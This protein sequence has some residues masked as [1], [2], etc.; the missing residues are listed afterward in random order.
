M[1]KMTLTDA[2]VSIGGTD[3][4]AY[5]RSVSIDYT[6]D[7]QDSTTMRSDT[8]ERLAGLKDWT[9]TVEFAQ[10]FDAGA[11]DDTLFPL[12]GTSVAVEIRP[13]SAA[14]STTN[15]GYIGNAILASYPPLG[16]S[17]GDLATSSVELQGSGT[18]TRSTV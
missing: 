13:T 16:N 11:V 6:A 8:R 9:M 4:S 1:P 10:D 14:R 7:T 3:L 18:L 17:I 2:F 12:V 15:P 5:V